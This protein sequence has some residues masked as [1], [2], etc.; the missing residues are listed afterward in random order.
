MDS[1]EFF[2][3]L[4]LAIYRIDGAYDRFAK[5]GKVKPNTMWVLYALGDGKTH[6]QRTL[7]EEWRFARSTVNTIIKEC[8]QQGYVRL[9]QIEGERRELKIRLTEKGKEFSQKLLSP[10]YDAEKELY[11]DFFADKGESFISELESFGD[12]MEKKYSEYDKKEKKDD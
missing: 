8:E 5:N 11:K 7:C 10:V 6:T 9:M 3:R 1:K 2:Y 4:A 12:E